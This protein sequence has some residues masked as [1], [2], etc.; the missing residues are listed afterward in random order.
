MTR[1]LSRWQE[2][3]LTE[4]E[5]FFTQRNIS[6]QQLMRK[7]AEEM[8]RLLDCETML[9]QQQK[10]FNA[11]PL[12][13][14]TDSNSYT[15]EPL[16]NTDARQRCFY[17]TPLSTFDE[18]EYFKCRAWCAGGDCDEISLMNHDITALEL[19]TFETLQHAVYQNSTLSSGIELIDVNATVGCDD[20]E[21]SLK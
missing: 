11:E 14:T 18:V 17:V 21:C 3:F 19:R 1:R 16:F 13:V 15:I 6:R 8:L 4:G 5:A 10:S 2:N 7:Y 9:P 12:R 20:F